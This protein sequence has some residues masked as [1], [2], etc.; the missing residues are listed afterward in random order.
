MLAAVIDAV[1]VTVARNVMS[2]DVEVRVTVKVPLPAL[3]FR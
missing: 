3:V 2:V 1:A